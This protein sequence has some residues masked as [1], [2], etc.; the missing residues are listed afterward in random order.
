[1]IKFYKKH[2]QKEASGPVKK[3]ETNAHLPQGTTCL[4]V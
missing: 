3:S 2:T 4:D 1:M